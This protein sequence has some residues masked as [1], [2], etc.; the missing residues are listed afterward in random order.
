M[1]TS[2]KEHSELLKKELLYEKGFLELKMKEKSF[3]RYK[4]EYKKYE[5]RQIDEAAGLAVLRRMRGE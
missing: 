1:N 4:E 3:D 2:S 5:T